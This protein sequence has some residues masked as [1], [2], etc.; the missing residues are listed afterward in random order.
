MEHSELRQ[1]LMTCPDLAELD[2]ASVASLFWRAEPQALEEGGV[3][4]AEGTALDETFC[5]LISGALVIE[6]AGVPV[7]E[8]MEQQIFGEMAYFTS[9]HTRTATVRVSSPQALFLKIQLT[10]EELGSA[11]FR[12]LKRYLGLEAWDRFVSG[13]QSIPYHPEALGGPDGTDRQAPPPM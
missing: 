12:T 10:R 7:G 6:L 3:I 1:F 2:E 13:S 4:Y 8:V 11:P 9:L 5:L